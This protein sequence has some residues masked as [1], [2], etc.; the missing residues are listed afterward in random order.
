[1]RS[2]TINRAQAAAV[3]GAQVPDLPEGHRVTAT[4][5]PHRAL[6]SVQVLDEFDCPYPGA[7]NLVGPDGRLWQ[8]S[9]NP[10]VNDFDLAIELLDSA[11]DRGLADLLDDRLFGIRVQEMTQFRSDQVRQ[12]EVDL[13]AGNL[14]GDSDPS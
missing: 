11:Y 12:F 9:S 3:L 6:W 2:V 5:V 1:M 14:R 4:R 7:F 10:F 8:L 13:L